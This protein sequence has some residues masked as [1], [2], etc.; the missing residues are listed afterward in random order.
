MLHVRRWSDRTRK[1][2]R[3]RRAVDRMQRRCSRRSRCDRGGRISSGRCPLLDRSGGRSGPAVDD[4]RPGDGPHRG[5]A[6]RRRRPREGRAGRSRASTSAKRSSRWSQQ[7]G[8]GCAGASQSGE[9]PAST[10]SARGACSRASSS[11]SRQSTAPRPNSRPPK[12]SCGQRRR[13]PAR[14]PSARAIPPWSR[15][16]SGVISARHVEVGEMAT[17]GKPLLTAFD[18]D[19]MRVIAE[20]P[21]S[22]HPGDQDS[23][24]RRSRCPRSNK[25]INVKSIVI[26]PAADP[27]THSTRVRLYLAQ[28]SSATSTRACTRAPISPSDRRASWSSPL[29][30]SFGGARSAACMWSTK[31]ASRASGRSDS[32][33]PAGDGLVEVLAGVSAGEKCRAGT[34]Q[35]RHGQRIEAQPA[36]KQSRQRRAH[37]TYRR[38]GCGHRRLADGLRHAQAGAAR[39]QDDRRLQRRLLPLRAVQSLGRGQ[40]AQ[41]RR[42]PVSA[43]AVPGEER[44]R[45]HRRWAQSA[46]TP[47]ENRL[48]LDG[49]ALGRTTTTSSLRPGRSSHSTRSKAWGRT[50]IPNRSATSITREAAGKRLG[51]VRQGSRARSSSARCRAPRATDRPTS[52]P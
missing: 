43:R 14:H 32:A 7:R 26:I 15:R 42:H 50:A 20:V 18:P 37:G 23:G 25:W 45:L 39:R 10:W 34:G 6:R 13:A 22:V 46:C 49:R 52:S 31:R 17:P 12:P 27:H 3:S 48:E 21:Q 41:A 35:G 11:A 5:A 8:A 29:Q 30:P 38:S 47:Q 33:S 28:R 36:H 51:R 16:I 4:L 2:H 19:D 40:L 44:H 9:R 24:G 1:R